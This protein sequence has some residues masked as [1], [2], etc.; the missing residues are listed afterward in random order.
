MMLASLQT[1]PSVF[2][3]P[4]NLLRSY[5]IDNLRADSVA[6]LTVGVVLIPQAIAFALLA[7][8]PPE[9]GLYSAVVVAIIGGLWGSSNHLHS[10]PTNTASIL[11]LS[12]LLPIAEPG[13]PT[14]IAAAGVLAVMVGAFRLIMGIARLGVLVNFVSDSVVIGFTA[15][16]GALICI[17]QINYLLRLESATD[18]SVLSTLQHVAL[19]IPD[20][21]LLSLAIGIITIGAIIGVRRLVP[22]IPAPLI[23]LVLAACL[24]W[25][26]HLEREGVVILGPLPSGLPTLAQISLVD[27]TLI[28]ELSTGALAMATIGLVEA[29]AIA[30][31]IA[32]QSG[33]RIDSNQEF[34]GQGLAN[35]ASGLLSGYPCSG[36][37]NRSALN[38]R[39]G[40]RTPMA[41]VFSGLV[42]LI[43]M[44]FLAPLTAY[45]PRAALAAVL[46]VIAIGMIDRQEMV[47][48]WRGARG[49]AVIMVVTLLATLLLPLQFAVLIGIIMALAYY[50]MKTSM[51]RVHAV[52][53]DD[54]FRHWTHQPQK[55]EC[56]QM[57]IIDILGDLYFGAV[58][59][60][61]ETIC[62]HRA[63]NT[64]QR[65]LLLRLQ[66]V[67]HCDISGIHMLENVVRMYR[68]Q[69]GD[70][71][72]VSIRD[73]VWKVMQSTKF[74]DFL[75]Q[76]HFLDE[77]TAIEYLFYRV[78][79]PAICIY[80]S[81]VRVFRECQNLPR[82]D[83]PVEIP[84]YDEISADDADE[85][86]PTDLWHCLR[87]DHAPLVIDVREPR[88]FRQGHVP[89]SRLIP[90]TQLITDIQQLP[91]SRSVVLVCRGGRRSAR[92]FAVARD[93]GYTNVKILQGGMVAWESAG[94]L[95]AVDECDTG[96]K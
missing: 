32:A 52:V 78:L 82:P 4:V 45:V 38:Y 85:I 23:G 29:T 92:V 89:Q 67:Q 25:V 44:L 18:P 46:I 87:E 21:H 27:L 47:R 9:M 65:F 71:Y 86:A 42:V 68:D 33:Q 13:T 81:N 41:A 30:R 12:T 24:V 15:G 66:S 55:P 20:I 83:Y 73:P 91:R 70:V 88:E 50:I 53:P 36:S 3:R 37:F 1:V 7:G 6:G 2:L 10:G 49:D 59:H 5:Q 75:G 84:L 74:C 16:A 39:V 43:G 94:L 35:I 77:D 60:V 64:S 54:A 26:F 96:G 93:T 17:G 34:I 22:K 58:N 95:A 79:D 56:P 19:H 72:M 80:E 31:S 69:G 28:G 51:P 8:L 40:A 76:D 48:I 90:F 57:S 61:E 14:F 62:R 63:R 11:V